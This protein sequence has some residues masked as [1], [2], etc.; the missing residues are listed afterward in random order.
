MTSQISPEEAEK[1]SLE[2]SIHRVEV[3]NDE[4]SAQTFADKL[5]KLQEFHNDTLKRNDSTYYGTYPKNR[6]K[7]RVKNLQKRYPSRSQRSLSKM[8]T[9]NGGNYNINSDGPSLAKTRSFK[10][11]SVLHYQNV[12]L[13]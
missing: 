7:G 12:F 10:K 5:K 8:F 11:S 9:N 1:E 3:Y 4:Q 2:A 6:A 13:R